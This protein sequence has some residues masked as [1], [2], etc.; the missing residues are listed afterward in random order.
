MSQIIPL[1]ATPAQNL[2]VTLAGQP[3]QIS[4]RAL[5]TGMF[6]DLLVNDQPIILGALVH[7][8]DRLVRAAYLGFIGDLTMVDTQG[9]ADP[10]VD[11][12][13]SRWVLVY[14]AAAELLNLA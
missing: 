3:C 9:A 2:T 13:G 11:F 5:S 7:D 12:L 4:L 14:L 6:L 8:R 1:Q 10:Q